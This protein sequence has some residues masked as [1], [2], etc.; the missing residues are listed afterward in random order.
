[1]S[2]QKASP[3]NQLYLPF[4]SLSLG[5]ERGKLYQNKDWLYQKYIIEK[6]S[7][8]EIGIIANSH[9]SIIYGWLKRFGIKTRTLSESMRMAPGNCKISPEKLT[10]CRD[11][12][13]LYQKYWIEKLSTP[14]IA[15]IVGTTGTVIVSWMRSFD[16]KIRTF[17]ELNKGEK[18]PMYGIRLCGERNHFWGKKHSEKTKELWS[19]QRKGK[20]KSEKWKNDL[21]IRQTF[22]TIKQEKRIIEL[23][24]AGLFME[25]IRKE[26][27]LGWSTVETCLR[28]NGISIR[29]G[30][31]ISEK[32]RLKLYES[33]KL[34]QELKPREFYIPIN[35]EGKSNPNWRGGIS[36]EPYGQKFNAILRRQI[37]KRDDYTCQICNTREN[38]QAHC[39]HHIDYNK[40]NNCPSNLI[41]LCPHCHPITNGSRFFWE[42]NFKSRKLLPA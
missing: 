15:E 33:L 5:E 18:N 13:W 38:G 41:S 39:C 26:L 36:Y 31:L 7:P 6:L 29:K 28:R 34:T 16:I 19:Q 37:R 12:D 20:K 21:I 23:Y 30:W 2:N 25:D 17:S 24:Q 35:Q 22:Y 4:D 11:K 1:M 40:K 42:S 10:K 3:A 9:N 32:Q 14:Q 8:R 27:D